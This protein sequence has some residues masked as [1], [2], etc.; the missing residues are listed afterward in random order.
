MKE[1]DQANDSSMSSPKEIKIIGQ[2]GHSKGS[3]VL[4][5][6]MEKISQT[7]DKYFKPVM[8]KYTELTNPEATTTDEASEPDESEKVL[9][10]SEPPRKSVETQVKM[11]D[12]KSLESSVVSKRKSLSPPMPQ[13]LPRIPSPIVA[14]KAT[15]IPEKRRSSVRKETV[16]CPLE[17]H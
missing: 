13:V 1:K 10:A 3:K 14:E 15:N 11:P 5:K 4:H 17:P 12:R 9:A 16:K 7:N 8:V 2:E 6:V